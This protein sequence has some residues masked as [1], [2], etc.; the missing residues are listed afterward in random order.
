MENR[1]VHTVHS[2][3]C[4]PNVRTYISKLSLHTSSGT[5]ESWS[6]FASTQLKNL[7]S[8][9]KIVFTALL[10]TN[11]HAFGII[12]ISDNDYVQHVCKHEINVLSTWTYTWYIVVVYSCIVVS[13]PCDFILFNNILYYNIKRKIHFTTP[14]R[15][16]CIIFF[17]LT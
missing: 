17:G 9:Y 10:E 14:T 7:L 2:E 4:L 8:S 11:L 16:I 5:Y 1:C 12:V 3:L 6:E 13:C 15:I